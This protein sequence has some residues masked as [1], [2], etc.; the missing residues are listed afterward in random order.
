MTIT[1]L[2]LANGQLPATAAALYTVPAG[3]SAVVKFITL[4][5]TNTAT[6]N[7]NLFF[8][9]AGS[10]ARRIIPVNLSVSASQSVEINQT[11]TM[12]AGDAIW[13]NTT[14][15]SVVDYVISGVQVT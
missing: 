2:N 1:Y 4:V 7:V 15:A 6:E 14:D 8:Q 3:A 9:K 11:I 5:N 13:G 12:G 10:T